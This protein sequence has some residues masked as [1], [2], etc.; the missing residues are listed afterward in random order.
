MKVINVFLLL[1]LCSFIGFG[2]SACKKTGPSEAVITVNNTLGKPV[3]GALVVL[4]QDSV[5]N[6][7]TGVQANVI[8]QTT[9]DFSGTA[10]FSFKLEAV[11]NVEV[12]K[13]TLKV[14]DF[15]KLEQN[16]IVSKTIILK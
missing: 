7:S 16:E 9:T 6:P 15:I 11:L 10:T 3:A 2:I 13:D 4:R 8:Q 1:V 14:R 5:V 12:S